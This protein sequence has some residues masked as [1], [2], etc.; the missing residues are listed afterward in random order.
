M[1]AEE[2]LPLLSPLVLLTTHNPHLSDYIKMFRLFICDVDPP[3]QGQRMVGLG[4]Q[5]RY[6]A[7]YYWITPTY[8]QQQILF[9]TLLTNLTGLAA[10]N[11]KS[12]N[13]KQ[14]FKSLTAA[15]GGALLAGQGELTRPFLR[16]LQLLQTQLT[17][18]KCSQL[19]H[20]TFLECLRYDSQ[21]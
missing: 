21:G 2:Q 15:F 16:L 8:S 18:H 19:C 12:L 1:T 10:S 13:M 17:A 6:K 3:D 5:Q 14:S 7:M 20:S 4:D 11:H 9:Y